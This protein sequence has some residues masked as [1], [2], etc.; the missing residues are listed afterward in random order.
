[1]TQSPQSTL[2]RADVTPQTLCELFARASY[3]TRLD[4]DG[5]VFVN[6]ES[7]SVYVSINEDN[8][9]IRY[10]A[11][12]KIDE[13]MSLESKHAFVNKMN[14]NFVFCR[15]SVPDKYSD[16]LVV[17]YYLSFGERINSF[18]VVSS[19]GLFARICSKCCFMI[20]DGALVK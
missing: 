11:Y 10:T 13:S 19:L 16:T 7:I 9:V 5:D 20:F 6:A 12:C 15:F 8:K 3:S 18:Q 14:D 4:D 17:D 2:W 1:M